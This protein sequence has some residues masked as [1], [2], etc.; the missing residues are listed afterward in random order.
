MLN[1][2][3]AVTTIFDRLVGDV[4]LKQTPENMDCCVRKGHGRRTLEI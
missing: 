2:W 1:L 3:N 4:S